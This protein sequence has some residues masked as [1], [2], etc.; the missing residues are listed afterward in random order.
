MNLCVKEGSGKYVDMVLEALLPRIADVVSYVGRCVLERLM[1]DESFK[2]KIL[3]CLDDVVKRAA[4][5]VGDGVGLAL[6]GLLLAGGVYLSKKFFDVK[7]GAELG[8]AMARM[9]A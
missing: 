5:H 7:G 1:R 2:G 9:A 6:K 4:P 8:D 3:A